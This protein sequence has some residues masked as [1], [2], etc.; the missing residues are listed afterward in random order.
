MG[1]TWKLRILRIAFA[2]AVVSA[3]A[4]AAGA[5]FSDGSFWDWV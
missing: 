4:L 5:N 2:L 3:L 1:M